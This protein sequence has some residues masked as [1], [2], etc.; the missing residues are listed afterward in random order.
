MI[1]IDNLPPKPS[2]RKGD[3]LMMIERPAVFIAEH[4]PA[5]YDGEWR[6]GFRPAVELRLATRKDVE[7]RIRCT[8]ADVEREQSR[9]Y[10][11]QEMLRSLGEKE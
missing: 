8:Q 3:V 6:Y 7:D 2:W 9:L 11:L 4:D 1:P 10:R 5:F